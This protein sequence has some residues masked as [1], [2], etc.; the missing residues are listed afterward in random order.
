MES[1][2]DQG[3]FEIEHGETCQHTSIFGQFEAFLNGGPV[4]LRHVTADN[5]G[6]EFEAFA[7]GLERLDD[8]VDLTKLTGTTRLLLVSVGI[9]D[10]LSDCL[11]VGHLGGTHVNFDTVR[12]LE[13]VDLNVEVKLTHPLENGLTGFRIRLDVERGVLANHFCNGITQLFGGAFILRRNSYGNHRIG[14]NHWLESRR[15]LRVAE[16]VTSLNVLETYK[17]HDVTR[18]GAVEVLTRVGVHF[19][20]TANTLGFAGEGVEDGISLTKG[21]GVNAGEG[22]RAILVVHDLESESAE[23]LVRIYDGVFAGLVTFHVH[24]GLRRNLSRG[25]KEVDHGVEHELHTLVL[26]SRSTIGREEVESDRAFT[27]QLLDRVD[28]RLFPF[29]VSFHDVVILFDDRFDELFAILF[30]LVN[31]VGRDVL[32]LVVLRLAGIIPDP[33]LAA[34]QINHA[35]EIVFDADRKHHHKR[36]GSEHV[37]DL[38]CDAVEVSA[39]SVELVDENDSGNA[40][41]VGVA[42]VGLGLGFDTTGSAENADATVEHFQ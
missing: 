21:A 2:V 17:S 34:E 42:P 31:H 10:G 37:L 5:L 4:F 15:I 14:E 22:Q 40:G 8:V 28:V 24:F 38:L 16:S 39:D 1:T 36:F 19:N 26:E 7:T 23:V 20:D 27:D 9:F 12:T 32:K 35:S 30:D 6:F 29:E 11:A 18:L 13:N 3:H 33:G 41:L 25:R